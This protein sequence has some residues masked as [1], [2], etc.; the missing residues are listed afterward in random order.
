M[1]YIVH[2]PCSLDFHLLT[3]GG[4]CLAHCIT[5]TY[6]LLRHYSV[7]KQAIAAILSFLRFFERGS[8]RKRPTLGS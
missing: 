8:I 3:L 4:S 6:F 1:S 2:T 7:K 5:Q